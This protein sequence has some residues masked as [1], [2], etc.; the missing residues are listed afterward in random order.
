MTNTPAFQDWSHDPG[1]AGRRRPDLS[2]AIA[3][4]FGDKTR[5]YA[6]TARLQKNFLPVLRELFPPCVTLV[7]EH[8]EQR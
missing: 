7:V 1:L 8:P 6:L 3:P 5:A 2:G 4:H